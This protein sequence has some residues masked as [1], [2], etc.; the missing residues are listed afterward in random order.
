MNQHA[1]EN[2]TLIVFTHCVY[3]KPMRHRR[4]HTGLEPF[5]SGTQWRTTTWGMGTST[6]WVVKVVCVA[7]EG[8]DGGSDEGLEKGGEWV[9]GIN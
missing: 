8:R 4:T 2:V 6:K 5:L 7:D 9:D 3:P 1:K